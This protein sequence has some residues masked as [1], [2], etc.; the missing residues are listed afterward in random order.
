MHIF[1]QSNQKHRKMFSGGI[2]NELDVTLQG[3]YQP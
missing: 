3:A 2:L 1:H